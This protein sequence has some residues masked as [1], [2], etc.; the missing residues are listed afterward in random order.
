MQKVLKLLEVLL[1]RARQHLKLQAAL[2]SLVLPV[3]LQHRQRE[4]VEQL[5][6][7]WERERDETRSRCGHQPGDT[8]RPLPGCLRGSG[9]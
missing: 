8:W 3:A 6:A 7:A 9:R 4:A 2:V 5:A 1:R